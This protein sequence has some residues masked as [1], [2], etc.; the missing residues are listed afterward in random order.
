MVFFT[1]AVRKTTRNETEEPIASYFVFLG[2]INGIQLAKYGLMF[3]R[4]N[5][6]N[7]PDCEIKGFSFYN[8]FVF[9]NKI[10]IESTVFSH[11]DPR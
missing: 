7:I 5:I 11:G 9:Y 1:E 2:Y 6:I 3:D 4:S 10:S 8:S